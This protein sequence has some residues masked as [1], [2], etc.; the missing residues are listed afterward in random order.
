MYLIYSYFSFPCYII[1]FKFFFKSDYRFSPVSMSIFVFL[2]MQ[3]LCIFPIFSFSIYTTTFSLVSLLLFLSDSVC[4]F[5][6]LSCLL[7]FIFVPVHLSN[8]LSL[9]I[10]CLLIY[11][12]LYTFPYFP[13]LL[14]QLHCFL[15][16][17]LFLIQYRIFFCSP[18]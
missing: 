9:F 16:I 7:L 6:L 13:P 1:F 5:F 17:H 12:P 15:A 14:S 3:H 4:S 18:I 11:L 8:N 2:P 10:L